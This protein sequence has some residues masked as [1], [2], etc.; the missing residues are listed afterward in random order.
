M[1]RKCTNFHSNAL[2]LF[3]AI[4][5]VYRYAIPGE[6]TRLI[7]EVRLTDAADRLAGTY[8]GGMRRRLSVAIALIGDPEV[9]FLDEPTTGMDPINRSLSLML[10][11]L[12]LSFAESMLM[13]YCIVVCIVV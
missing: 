12:M 6:A 7:E 10:L 11:S 3:A 5:G 4:K 13:L 9:V 2:Q 8:S 1:E